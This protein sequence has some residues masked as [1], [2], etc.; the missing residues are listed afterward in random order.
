MT[1]REKYLQVRKEA[2]AT[3]VALAV[4]IVFWLVAGFGTA[5]LDIKIFHLPLWAVL[6]T[7]GT[8]AMAIILVKILTLFVFKDMDL[9]AGKDG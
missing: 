8:W 5:G 7:A 9:E 3:G 6:G 4:L 2:L 1:E